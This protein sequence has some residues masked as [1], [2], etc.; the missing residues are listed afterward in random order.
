[1]QYTFDEVADDMA[2]R[3]EDKKWVQEKI[4]ETIHPQGLRK[5]LL[6]LK[7]WGLVG[8]VITAFLALFGIAVTLIIF[9][10]T[11]LER[12]AQFQTRT[13][14]FEKSAE[15]RLAKIEDDLLSLKVQQSPSRVLKDLSQMH[16]D[17]FVAAIPV[18]R[19]VTDLPPSD[20]SATDET[21]HNIAERLGRTPE[22][23]PNY[24]PTTLRFIQFASSVLAPQ[25][26]VPPHG[27]P[28][29]V[30]SNNFGFGFRLRLKGE[31]I[32][33]DGGDLG[34]DVQFENCRII[35]T[36]HPVRM[37]GV[38]FINCV[39]EM[40]TELE[41]TP[42]LKSVAYTLLASDLKTVKMTLG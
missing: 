28:T 4:D 35:F 21:L 10:S 6:L 36:S 31:V 27:P 7:E 12:N 33:L 25:K 39:F 1:M 3:N 32:L 15:I 20:I 38:T 29:S 16:P 19:K 13:E 5:V 37:Q 14:D 41:P 17:N 40:P 9:T 34:S 30:I 11:R 18:L 24:W 2:L 8:V 22:T 42:Y 23:A 26:D